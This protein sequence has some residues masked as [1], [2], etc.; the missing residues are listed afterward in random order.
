MTAIATRKQSKQNSPKVVRG[1]H[2]RFPGVVGD[3]GVCQGIA[4]PAANAAGAERPAVESFKVLEQHRHRREESAFV[5]VVG[6]H[7]GD[8][9][10]AGVAG[11]GDDGGQH[12]G[13]LR[14]DD[15]QPLDVGLGRGDVQQRD[16]LA[17]VGQPVLDEAVVGQLGQL[18]DPD[19]FSR[20]PQ[21]VA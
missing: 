18:L 5:A 2:E 19:A 8:G 4:D 20:G 9:T 11:A 14:G 3:L 1:E 7:V 10:G 16:E 21:P 15:Q 17:G 12:V 6:D 13:Q